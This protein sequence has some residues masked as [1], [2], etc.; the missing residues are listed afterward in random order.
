MHLETLETSL[1]LAHPFI[2]THQNRCAS[3]TSVD[4]FMNY[5]VLDWTFFE[6]SGNI[7]VFPVPP[8]NVFWLATY[9]KSLTL[10]EK[11]V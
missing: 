1:P 8:K 5:R 4:D 7:R 11:C 10:V 3:T 9:I 6:S 2:T